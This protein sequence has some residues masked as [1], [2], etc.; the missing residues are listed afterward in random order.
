MF[1]NNFPSLNSLMEKKVCISTHSVCDGIVFNDL[2]LFVY[3]AIVAIA[4]DFFS[5]VLLHY[6]YYIDK[7]MD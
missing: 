3:K 4:A 7:I 6:Y 2:K 5:F 1:L